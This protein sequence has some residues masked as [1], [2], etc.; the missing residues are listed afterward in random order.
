MLIIPAIDMKDHKVV[1]LVQGRMNESSVYSHS[2]VKTAEKW[3]QEGANRLH[4]VD[5]N[6]AFEGKPIHFDAVAEVVQAFPCVELEVGG[7]IRELKTIE[8]YFDL[9]V[10]YCILGT[11]AVQDPELMKTAA[12]KFP[13]QMIL[14]VDAKD[15]KVAIRGWDETSTVTA[16]ELTKQFQDVSIESVIY[17]DVSKDGMLCGMNFKKIKEMKACGVPV[18][19]SGGLTTLDDIDE[20]K[21]MDGIHGV[22]AGKAIYE[23]RFSVKDAIFRVGTSC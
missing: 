10:T 3:I 16:L 9:G 17:T 19:A 18:I 12:R 21:K 7:G 5:L 8:R 13:K 22:I 23:G 11:S 14:G 4:L 2:I 20:L 1:R 15:G 6:G